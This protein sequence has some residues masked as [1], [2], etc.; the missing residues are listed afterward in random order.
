MNVSLD[1]LLFTLIQEMVIDEVEDKRFPRYLAYD[2]LKFQG[3]DVGNA[4]FS[5]RLLCIEKEIVQTRAKYIQEVCLSVR[6][7]YV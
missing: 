1:M 2:I 3:E 7:I 6:C 5:V 4:R